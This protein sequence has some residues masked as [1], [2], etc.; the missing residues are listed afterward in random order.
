MDNMYD[1]IV[2]LCN[3]RSIKPGKMCSETGLSRG[4]ISDLKMGRTKELSAKNSKII[5]DYFGVSVDY[6]VGRE[7]QKTTVKKDGGSNIEIVEDEQLIR[8]PVVGSISAGYTGLAVEEYTGEYQIIPASF[9]HGPPQNYFVLHVKGNSMYPRL[10]ND[11]CVLVRKTPVIDNGK[12]AVVLYNGDEATVKKVN[13]ESN[14]AIELIPYNP[15]Y[16]IK[17]I[18]GEELNQCKILGEVVKLIRD[19]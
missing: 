14:K 16:Q 12:V 5:A 10:L 3:S 19:L 11:D 18:E 6:L 1:R 15:E 7:Q 4:M 9:L 17:R 2:A 8:F 13:Y